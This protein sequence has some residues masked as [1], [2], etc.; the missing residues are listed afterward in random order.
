MLTH[1][2]TLSQKKSDKK[3]TKEKFQLFQKKI[4]NELDRKKLTFLLGNIFSLE[5]FLFL[6]PLLLLSKFYF[7]WQ[8]KELVGLLFLSVFENGSLNLASD[9][10]SRLDFHAELLSL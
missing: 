2:H 3:D 8:T 6:P 9:V 4:V 7:I 5:D 1:T 10:A